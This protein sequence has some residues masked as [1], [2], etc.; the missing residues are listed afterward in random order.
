M[1]PLRWLT[2]EQVRAYGE[3]LQLPCYLYSEKELRANIAEAKRFPVNEGCGFVLRYAMK[4]NPTKAVLEIMKEE[5]VH[6]DASS[7]WEVFRAMRLG[8]EPKCIQLT[9]QQHA[10]RFKEL[11]DLGVKFTACS[12]RQLEEFGKWCAAK[13]A[14]ENVDPKGAFPSLQWPSFR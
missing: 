8:F 4:A 7:E 3:S 6:I 14:S 12:L 13:C 5:G 11:M 10:T 9:A 1:E 2:E